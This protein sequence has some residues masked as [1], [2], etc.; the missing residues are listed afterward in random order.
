MRKI[1]KIY[2]IKNR[3]DSK[4]YIGMT[5][6]DINIRFKE[7]LSNKNMFVDKCMREIGVDNF[8]FD[9][10]YS[11]KTE[12]E[13]RYLEKY[14]ILLYDC[15]YPKGY[16]RTCPGKDASFIFNELNGRQLRLI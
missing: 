1:Y 11:C 5:S 13:A 15:L 4:K 9:E 16:N 6:R 2:K 10:I 14:F 3:R 7:H 12:R 8:E